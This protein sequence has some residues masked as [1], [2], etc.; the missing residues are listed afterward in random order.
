MWASFTKKSLRSRCNIFI[1]ATALCDIVHQVAHLLWAIFYFGGIEVPLRTCYHIQNL[2]QLGCNMGSTL[3]LMIALD[4][5]LCVCKPALYERLN[6]PF[7]V[8]TALIVA[9]IP[10]LWIAVYAYREMIQAPNDPVPCVITGGLLPKSIE[11]FFT[12]NSS[13]ITITMFLYAVIWM[14]VKKKNYTASRQMLRSI[15]TVSLCVIGGWFITMNAGN[16]FKLFGIKIT[17]LVIMYNGQILNLSVSLNYVIYFIMSREYRGA[18][19]QQWRIM[20]C[21]MLQFAGIKVEDT[22]KFSLTGKKQLSSV[23]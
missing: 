19:V 5:L 23:S 22:T 21:G 10:P 8:P 11:L 12:V 7:Y 6:T 3:L 18:F 14:F 17:S 13:I 2:P 9:S 1:A 4:R 16:V 20:S 15:T